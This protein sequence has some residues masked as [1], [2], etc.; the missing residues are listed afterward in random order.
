MRLKNI[1]AIGLSA[2]MM[3]GFAGCANSGQSK[4]KSGEVKLKQDSAVDV[5]TAFVLSLVNKDYDTSAKLLGAGED[6][7]YFTKGDVEWY[8]PRSSFAAVSDYYEKKTETETKESG[9]GA[10]VV[11]TV[12]LK[13][14][15][16]KEDAGKDFSVS[17]TM[18]NEN[19]WF[20]NAPEFYISD[21]YFVTPGGDTK[22]AI[23][24]IDLS[25]DTESKTYGSAGLRKEY[26][27][28]RIGK[29]EKT[30][31]V[32]ASN[33]FGSSVF[34]VNPTVNSADE[35]YIC[36][37]KLTDEKAY[38]S[39]CDI[40]NNCY[41]DIIDGKQASDLLK[42]VSPNADSNITTQIHNGIKTQGIDKGTRGNDNFVCSNVRAC[43]GEDYVSHWL[44]DK[45]VVV[46]F[47]YDMG[48]RYKLAN[49]DESMTNSTSLQLYYADGSY[50]I[51]NPGEKFFSWYNEFTN[52]T[53]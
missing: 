6:T 36:Q 23:N 17:L 39:I 8:V 30:I 43:S 37:V 29:S 9:S 44:T 38:Q 35:P 33:S 16:N 24:E 42:Y 5:A 52:K 49:W 21:W 28:S 4:S 48:W 15:G 18:N 12:K 31:S 34:E 10:S 26:K 47:N 53:N 3:L 1:L 50:T 7:P 2:V 32:S 40:W 46:Y 51:Q 11:V 22:V 13:E 27:I 14:K 19:K 45:I 25:A 41:K 20:I